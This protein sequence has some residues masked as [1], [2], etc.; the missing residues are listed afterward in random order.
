MDKNK[1]RIDLL[2]QQ[3][4]SPSELGAI[5]ED[6]ACGFL[7]SKRIKILARNWRCRFGELD[8]IAVEDSTVVF[9]EVKTRSGVQYGYPAEAITPDKLA[10]LRR[11][12]GLWLVEQSLG[13]GS[14]RLDIISVLIEPQSDPVI[15]HLI[16]VS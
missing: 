11:L 6:L 16:G 7:I 9:V 8:I 13:W 14:V 4:F 2:N 3:R 10:R 12:A 15:D 5:G 1:A